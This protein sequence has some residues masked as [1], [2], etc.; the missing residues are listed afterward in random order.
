[1]L[2]YCFPTAPQLLDFAA[3]GSLKYQG[4]IKIINKTEIIKILYENANPENAAPMKKY[5]K[6]KF[7]FLG[8]KKPERNLLS[9]QF[10]KEAK[11]DE[12]IDWDFVFRLW[13]LPERE[14]QYLA[15]EYLVALKGLLTEEDLSKL[16]RLVLDKSWWDTVD[17]IAA[18]LVGEIGVRNRGFTESAMKKWAKSEDIWIAR[19]ALLFQLKYKED[20]NKELLKEVI[21]CN[22]GTKEFFIDKAIGWALREYSKTDPDFV[23]NVIETVDLAPLAKREGG[24]YV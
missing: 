3:V 6:D 18:K 2:N 23:R 17:L 19:T 10:L 24:K 13:S 21:E 1:L 8:L 22:L 9:K 14:F 5:M 16:K 20:T 15:M 4:V 7:D 12:K 11:K